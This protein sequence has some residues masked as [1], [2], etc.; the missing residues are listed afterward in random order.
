MLPIQYPRIIPHSDGAGIIDAVGAGV[1]QSR[2]GERVWIWNARWNRP[3][4]TAAE[5]VTL[6][7]EQAVPLPDNTDFAAG[8]CLG[9]PAL[10][11]WQAVETD[12]GVAVRRLG[13]GQWRGRCGRPLRGADGEAPRVPQVIAT[14]S[15]AAEGRACA[16]PP[17]PTF[18]IDR[19]QEDVVANDQ[20]ASP[21]ARVS[22]A[23]SR[24]IFPATSPGCRR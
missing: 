17:A 7:A 4:G 14:V 1:P 3:F 6:P 22:P 8:A 24:W 11:A 10:T 15:S 5:F 2:M 20:A 16:R 21:A 9:I 18:V 23:P 12:G 19:K 13:L